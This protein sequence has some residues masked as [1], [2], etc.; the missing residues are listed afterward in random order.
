M[1]KDG[2]MSRESVVYMPTL[3]CYSA[4]KK[5]EVLPHRTTLM[6]LDDIMLSKGSSVQSLSR[7]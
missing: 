5:K 3:K 6:N 1:S 2:G 7:V 4:F